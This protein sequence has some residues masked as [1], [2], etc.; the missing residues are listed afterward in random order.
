MEPQFFYTIQ[1]KVNT[2]E[3]ASTLAFVEQTWQTLF[4]EVPMEYNFVDDRFAELFQEDQQLGTLLEVF[5]VLAI[6][7]AILGLFGLASFLAIEKEKEMSIRKVAGATMF[8][9]LKKL[10]WTFI[11]LILLANVI[12]L[13][14]GFIFMNQWLG[15]FVFRIDMPVLVFIGATGATLL[16]AIFTVG[17]HAYKTARVNPATILSQD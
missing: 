8:E 4:P 16:V 3:V 11:K 17:Y 7:I 13:P 15:E 14:L 6:M 1:V 2:T 5:A 9:I 10:S 12:A